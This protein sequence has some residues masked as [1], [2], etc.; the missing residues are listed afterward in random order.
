MKSDS[1]P[2]KVEQARDPVVWSSRFGERISFTVFRGKL[3]AHVWKGKDKIASM[4][5]QAVE[6]ARLSA[7][8]AKGSKL[9]QL[10]DEAWR[11]EATRQARTNVVFA[12]A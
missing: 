1:A 4:P 11:E 12:G 6:A 8:A 3:W 10:Q 2:A 7:V 9:A 5:F